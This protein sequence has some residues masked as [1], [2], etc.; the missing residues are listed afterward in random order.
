MMQRLARMFKPMSPEDLAALNTTTDK[1]IL[2]KRL[3]IATA[4]LCFFI[5]LWM[6]WSSD[7]RSERLAVSTLESWLFFLAAYLGINLGQ[8][9]VKRATDK[10]TKVA[11]AEAKAKSAPPTVAVAGNVGTVDASQAPT[12]AERAAVQPKPEEPEWAQGDPRAG[13]L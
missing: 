3:T 1:H 2:G 5:I 4:A 8:F 6:A 12:T 10:D 7:D 9:A 13:I 11:V